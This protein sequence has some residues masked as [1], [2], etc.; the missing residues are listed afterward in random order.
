MDKISK[1]RIFIYI[2]KQVISHIGLFQSK[3]SFV[4]KK[5]TISEL[6][7]CVLKNMYNLGTWL[8]V[9]TPHW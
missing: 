3:L 6:L 1:K 4:F 7:D 9:H 5:T 8:S 2:K